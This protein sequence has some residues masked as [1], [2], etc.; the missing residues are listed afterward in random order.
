[1]RRFKVAKEQF[2]SEKKYSTLVPWKC[3]IDVEGD[4]YNPYNDVDLLFGGV[5]NEGVGR[6][7]TRSGKYIIRPLGDYCLLYGGDQDIPP[8]RVKEVVAIYCN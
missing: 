2:E 7:L 4:D 5:V 6:W 8:I 3:D 1:M